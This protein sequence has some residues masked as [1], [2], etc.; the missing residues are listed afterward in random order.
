M[1]VF[2]SSSISCF[3]GM[4]LRYHLNDFEMVPVAPIIIGISFVFTFHMCCISVV[5][6]FI[7]IIFLASFLTTFPVS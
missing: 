6:V 5:K 7:H 3:P 1:A 4:L 2:F